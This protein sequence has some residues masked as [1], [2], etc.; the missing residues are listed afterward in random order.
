M[1]SRHSLVRVMR[2]GW[3]ILALAVAALCVLAAPMATAASVSG[4]AT[5][6]QDGDFEQPVTPPGA[7]LTFYDGHVFSGWHVIGSIDLNPTG[8]FRAA[9]GNQD[10]D[11]NGPG[12][13]GLWRDV[14]TQPGQPYQL[15]FWFAGNPDT[16]CGP[17]G[18]KTMVVRA[19]HTWRTFTFDTTGHSLQDI[20]WVSRQVDFTAVGSNTRIAFRSKTGTCAGPMIDFVRMELLAG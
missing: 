18:I 4:P 10:V 3:T 12:T 16:G 6:V 8:I 5:V 7:F 1:I 2:S 15:L 13:G 17:Q 9:H 11:L 14:R 20:G 19:A